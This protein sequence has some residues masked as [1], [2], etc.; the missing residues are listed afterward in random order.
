VVNAA[1]LGSDRIAA[2]VGLDRHRIHPCRGDYFTLRSPTTYRHLIYPVKDP[3][4]PG[5]GIHL[6]IDRAGAYKL[7]P[8][9]QYVDARDDFSPAEHKHAIFLAAAQRLLGPLRPDQIS[10]DGCGIRPKLR[11]PH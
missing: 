5:L 4:D 2:L 10:Y 9:A 1:G 7:G 3:R 6:T 8:D 11:A